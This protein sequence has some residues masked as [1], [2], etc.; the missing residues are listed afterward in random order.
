MDYEI[1]SLVSYNYVS[2]VRLAS[3]ICFLEKGGHVR[4]RIL[5]LNPSKFAFAK[6]TGKIQSRKIKGN[7]YDVR[8]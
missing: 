8:I 2:L 1:S 4:N 3:R 7:M 6:Y 5:N